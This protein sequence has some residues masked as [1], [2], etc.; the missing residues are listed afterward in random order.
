M[1]EEVSV[2]SIMDFVKRPSLWFWVELMD[3]G[4]RRG[5]GAM[6]RRRSSD[7]SS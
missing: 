4:R 6:R 3:P 2:V 7:I 1:C 5:V